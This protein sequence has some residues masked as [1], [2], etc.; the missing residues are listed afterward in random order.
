MENKH[1]SSAELVK[2]A[3]EV[4]IIRQRLDRIEKI[5]LE[6][7]LNKGDFTDDLD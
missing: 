4:Q 1:L 6:A 7:Q 2:V 5:I 3:Q